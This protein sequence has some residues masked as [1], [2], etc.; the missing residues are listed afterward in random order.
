MQEIHNANNGNYSYTINLYNHNGSL[1]NYINAKR[2]NLFSVCVQF[3]HYLRFPPNKKSQAVECVVWLVLIT[4][5]YGVETNGTSRLT[6]NWFSEQKQVTSIM[7]RYLRLN[8]KDTEQRYSVFLNQCSTTKR[9]VLVINISLQ[10]YLQQKAKKN[11][12]PWIKQRCMFE[13]RHY[14][15]VNFPW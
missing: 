13:L 1:C 15:S 10:S 14:Q 7:W 6:L 9:D 12:A 4:W 2:G 11:S 8:L 5:L 3:A